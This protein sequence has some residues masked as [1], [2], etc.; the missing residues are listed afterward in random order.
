LFAQPARKIAL[1]YSQFADEGLLRLIARADKEALGELYDR[2]GGLVFS[3]ALKSVGNRETA[4]EITQDVFLR[5][6][7]NAATYQS[8]RGKVSTWIAS[9][10]RNRAIDMI[11]Q[12]QI[13][14]ESQSVSWEAAPGANLPEQDRLEFKVERS[15]R[16]SQV[17]SALANLPGEQKQALALAYFLGYTHR[18]IAEAL[19]LPLG[20]VKTRI[21]LALQKLRSYLD[22]IGPLD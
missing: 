5:I 7:Q 17:H 21:R 9:I 16:R 3:I 18:E 10:T 11:R 15:E 22:G 19:D 14:P 6:W 13:R 2:Y 12:Y 8:Q 1:N 20:T 4:E